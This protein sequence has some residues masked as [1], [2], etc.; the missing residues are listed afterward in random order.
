MAEQVVSVP[1]LGGIDESVDQDRLPPPGMKELKNVVVRKKQRFQKR[2]GYSL[3][4]VSGS[5][6]T[7]ATTYSTSGTSPM[8]LLSESISGHRGPSGTK[9]VAAADGKLFEFV[10]QDALRGY[11]YVNDIP[12]ALGTVIPVDTSSGQCMEVESCIIGPPGEKLRV[13]AWTVGE[14]PTA[15]ASDDSVWR[16]PSWNA[17]GLYVAIQR[18]DTGAFLSAP[19]RIKS[20]SGA[21]TTDV[22]NLRVCECY[23]SNLGPDG[24]VSCVIAWQSGVGASATLE[25]LRVRSD[26]VINLTVD[27]FALCSPLTSGLPPTVRSFDIAQVWSASI[28]VLPNFENNVVFAIC[29]D[30]PQSPSVYWFQFNAGATFGW[31]LVANSQ[32]LS[33]GTV[34]RTWTPRCLRGVMIQ[35]DKFSPDSKYTVSVRVGLSDTAAAAAPIDMAIVTVLMEPSASPGIWRPVVSTWSIVRDMNYQ[36]MEDFTSIPTYAA[37]GGKYYASKTITQFNGDIWADALSKTGS[38][39]VTSYRFAGQQPSVLEAFLP[40]GTSQLYAMDIISG[41]VLVGE[42]QSRLYLSS[43]SPFIPTGLSNQDLAQWSANSQQSHRYP[44]SMQIPVNL[45]DPAVYPCGGALGGT[46]L[47]T[48]YVP[49]CG[50]NNSF[51][52]MPTG[53]YQGNSVQT[54]IAGATTTTDAVAD[55]VISSGVDHTSVTFVGPLGSGLTNGIYRPRVSIQGCTTAIFLV[56]VTLGSISAI[57]V[58]DSGTGMTVGVAVPFS[59]PENAMYP[60]S[61]EFVSAGTCDISNYASSIILTSCGVYVS[62]PSITNRYGACNGLAPLVGTI[63]AGV[64]L[65]QFST[66]SNTSYGYTFLDGGDTAA[67]KTS[68]AFAIEPQNCVHRWSSCFTTGDDGD[69]VLLAISSTG[70]NPYTTPSGDAPLSAPFVHSTNNYFETYKWVPVPGETVLRPRW[71]SGTT[72]YG[73]S[74]LAGPWRIVSTLT[75]FK[76]PDV[77]TTTDFNKQRAVVAIT[78]TGDDAQRSQYLVYIG[79]ASNSMTVVAPGPDETESSTNWRYLNNKGMFVESINAPRVLSIPFGVSRM[80]T[81]ERDEQYGSSSFSRTIEACCG[82]IRDGSSQNTSSIG[83]LS[84]DLKAESWRQAMPYADYTILN[85]G[86]VSSFDGASCNE[87][88]PMMW[89]Q[90]ALCSISD[91]DPP[92]GLFDMDKAYFDKLLDCNP[93]SS[94]WEMGVGSGGARTVCA[95]MNISRPFFAAEAGLRYFGSSAFN[96]F[97]KYDGWNQIITSFGGKPTDDYQSISVDQRMTTYK[98]NSAVSGNTSPGGAKPVYFYGKYGNYASTMIHDGAPVGFVAW[99]PRNL[100]E[101]VGGG[102]GTVLSC[103]FSNSD[104]QGDM[105]MRWVYECADGTGRIVKSAPSIPSRYTVVSKLWVDDKQNQV[106]VD[107]YKYGFFAPRL[108][109]TNRLRVGADDNKRVTLQPYTTAEPFGSVFYRMPF[110]NWESPATAFTSERGSDRQLCVYESSEYATGSSPYGFVTNNL[111]CFHG[112]NG[113]YLGILGAPYLYTTGGEV[114]N[115]CPPSVKCMT[116][117]RG[118]IVLGGADDATIVWISKEI[119][120]QDAPAFS[121]LMTVKISDGGA[122]TGLGS[123]S[124]ALVVFKADQ[125][126]VLTGEMPDNTVAG[127]VSSSPWSQTLGDP[128]RLVNGLGCISHRSVISTPAGVF[129]QSARAIELMGQNMAVTPIGLRVMDVM[130]T[131]SEVVSTTHKAVDS[132]VIFCCQKPTVN[133]GTNDQTD[134]SQ[135]VLLVYNYAEDIW[136]QHTMSEFGVGPATVG[137]INDQTLLF[138]GGNAYQTSDTKFYDTSVA[139]NSWVTMSGETAPIAMNQAQGYQRV[140]RVVLMGDPIPALPAAQVYQPHGMTIQIKTDWDSTQTATWTEAQSLDVYGK[141]GREFFQVHVRDQ[142]CQK[143]SIRWE[144]SPGVTIN[145]GYG[146]AFSNIA[147]TVGVK[148]GLNKR[149]TQAAEH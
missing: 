129:F 97:Q 91:A 114:P 46:Q 92:V 77:A 149:M 32:P 118:R 119:T 137:D 24:D 140:K 61:P 72:G 83:S 101:E 121:D 48:I 44:A 70:A 18:V 107:V 75:L 90:R 125:I 5:P 84:Y 67:P 98:L 41:G 96:P 21:D 25:G 31:S 78:P 112:S 132:E 143:V 111:T 50:P 52:L 89:P 130:A 12:A 65:F 113:E 42:T 29:T 14:R 120:E 109:L 144:D 20:F 100:S 19:T 116:V 104:A 94:L 124:R 105:L 82:I 88:S 128:Y 80:F 47:G 1:L 36:T 74:A 34:G 16:N 26:G 85:G 71:P 102:S 54:V 38:S 6:T 73:I 9:V 60:G 56:T 68:P 103:S 58:A 59:I 30:D 57:S 11:R 79:D 87:I 69:A 146:V 39:P 147:L 4:S 145:T 40:D 106:S 15:I 62:P 115:M 28:G 63:S 37:T 53:Y 136:S 123:L 108:E 55:V 66:I 110:R 13:T 45:S 86:V 8:P 17:N 27:V 33:G 127:G 10:N 76:R 139:G 81:I 135:F 126:H 49:N 141:Q 131:Y 93:R 7:P 148:S 122:V 95:L 23:A 133:G 3:L 134:G 51:P 142:K 2:E 43:V 22:R 117:H 138:V 35:A 64:S 99:L